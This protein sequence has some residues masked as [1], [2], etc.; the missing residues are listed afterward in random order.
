MAQSQ[1]PTPES[2]NSPSDNADSII[3]A[4][5]EEASVEQEREALKK[6]R[7][8]DA[9]DSADGEGA[10]AHGNLHFGE[11]DQGE[12]KKYED[13]PDDAV[14]SEVGAPDPSHGQQN[15]GSGDDGS[16]NEIVTS[17]DE[18]EKTA[19]PAN[20]E[21]GVP[22][23]SADTS[24][25]TS[26]SSLG[27]EPVE[28]TSSAK[29]TSGDEE[30][31]GAGVERTPASETPNESPTDLDLSDTSV[32][33]NDAGAVVATLTTSDADS[34]D[35]ATYS[36]VEDPSGFFEVV[37]NELRLRDGVSLDHEAQDAY[38]I[39][40]QVEDSAGNV[41][42][43]TVTIDVND[44]NEGPSGVSLSNTTIDE[45]D[46]G[47]VVG[48]VSAVDPDDGDSLTYTVS[49]DR[50]EIVGNELRLKDGVS[51]DHETAETIDV[52]VTATDQGGLE[53]SQ[54]F[55]IN[56]DD[57]NEGPSGVSLSNT[58]IDENDAGAVVGTVS[59]VDPDDG[60][61]LTYTVSD[62]RF[63][64]VGNELR[65]KDGV[66][67]DH[68]TAETIDVTVTATDQGGLESSQAF[69]IN[70]DDVNEGPSGVS[71]SN[72]TIDENDAGAVVG[73]VSA[74]DPDDGDSLT[75]TVSD[76]R[77]EIVGNELRLKDGVSLDHEAAE[78][79]DVTVT[80]TDQGGLESS[81]A[82][83]INVDDVNEGPIGRLAL[84]HHYR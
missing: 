33:E 25:A 80:A 5:S 77:F 60:D 47:A 4:S 54:A 59:A 13:T 40:L 58:T 63:E 44:V 8:A 45:N 2:N 69:T 22:S 51:L 11:E 48:T 15:A 65:L 82:F 68:E 61:S 79:I 21:G 53:S 29:T 52:T 12:L 42:T 83:T 23:P 67:L 24:Y 17:T 75:Y 3:T 28:S 50:F 78:T 49:D 62:D 56:V 20:A 55:T 10:A 39:V 32:D 57:V 27:D 9:P 35:T 81:Q 6:A 76:D 36:I 7:D 30:P 41:Y 43:E 64:I 34:N 74:V 31:T 72:T 70:V 38:E 84:Q 18:E 14:P 66:S 73:T 19:D 26:S 1:S 16:D 37:G 46:A 71:L